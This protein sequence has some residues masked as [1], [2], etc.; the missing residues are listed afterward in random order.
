MVKFLKFL[1]RLYAVLISPLLGRNC[2]FHPTCSCYAHQALEKHGAIKGL[3]LAL[4]RLLKCHPWSRASYF[5]PV[6]EEF[7][8]SIDRPRSIRYKQRQPK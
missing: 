1:I 5:D 8:W 2:R 7:E 6:P 4:A 3:F